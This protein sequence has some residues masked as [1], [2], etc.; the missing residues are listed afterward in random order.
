LAP[1]PPIP[2][3]FPYTTLFRSK[4]LIPVDGEPIG[5]PDV[6]GDDRFFIDMRI[7]D[8][9]DAEH[10]TMLGKLDKAG[11]PVVRIVLQSVEHLG[12]E[13]DRKSTRLNSSHLGISYAV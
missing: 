6:Y 8:E 1:R 11:H 2:P 12:Q 9:A 4:G 10:E 7:K 3:P 5:G 13:L